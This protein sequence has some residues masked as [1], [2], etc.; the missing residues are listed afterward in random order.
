MQRQKGGENMNKQICRDCSQQFLLP[1][2]KQVPDATGF[3][4]IYIEV[5]PNCCSNLIEPIK[6]LHTPILDSTDMEL[7]LK[8]ANAYVALIVVKKSKSTEIVLKDHYTALMIQANDLVK[9]INDS[10]HE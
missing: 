7:I 4:G 9:K 6:G 1:H 5:C 8:M 2:M 10:R 3:D